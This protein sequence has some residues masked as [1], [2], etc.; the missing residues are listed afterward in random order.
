MP[1]V[2]K[3][4]PAIGIARVGDHPDGFFVGPE[5][6]GQPPVEIGPGGD[7]T[8]IASYKQKVGT[9]GRL[10]RQAARFRVYEYD[11]QPDGRLTL[12]RE[13]TPDQPDRPVVTWT[14]DLV[15][16]KAAGSKILRG[17]LVEPRNPGIDPAELTIR[18]PAPV[19]VA[20]AGESGRRFDQG[21]FR[22]ESVYLGEL[23]TDRHGRLLVLGGRGVSRSVPAGVDIQDFAN[24]PFWYDDVADG[25]VTATVTFAGGPPVP[26]QAPAWVIVA[27]PDYA[28]GVGAIVTL[29]EVAFQAALGNAAFGIAAPSPVS[30]RRDVYP[31]LRRASDHRW[32]HRWGTWATFS[33]DWALLSR[34]D[35]TSAAA[36][37]AWFDRLDPDGPEPPAG[38]VLAEYEVPPYLVAVLKAWRDGAFT[39]DWGDP[40]APPALTPDGLDRAALEACTGTNF[41]PGIEASLN[42][43]DPALYAAP[44]RLS[45][46]KVKAG[47]MT[48]VMAVPWQ[49]DFLKCRRSWWPSQRPDFV[50]ATAA[51]AGAEPGRPWSAGADADHEQLVARFGLLGVV[52][53]H[54]DNGEVVHLEVDRDLPRS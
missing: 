45:H 50:Y 44:F 15:N 36:R 26:V 35:G 14:V 3:I 24:N 6:A 25:P 34:N 51:A 13:L 5:V 10:K 40:A 46:Q 4:H 8:P 31:V 37:A 12:V 22:G 28:P 39:D 32:T 52:V 30:F 18:N 17:G 9:T 19:S 54:T 21:R 33:R 11:Q 20:G 42:V 38:P 49:A 2:Y 23:G 1:K 16:S 29:Y 41:F 48:Q 53:P 43:K 47:D 7:E 27:P